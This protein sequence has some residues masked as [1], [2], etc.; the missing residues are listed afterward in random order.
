MV[1]VKVRQ[2][3]V[4]A[5]R[6]VVLH[7]DAERPHAGARVEH[8]RVPA[9][10]PHFH[11]RGVAAVAHGVGPRRGDRAAAAPHADAHQ[12]FP[13]SSI[14]QNTATAPCITPV[15]PSNGYAVAS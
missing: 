10:E 9:R 14:G 2:H 4:Q 11:A 3:D 15:A 6:H 1:E 5:G 13:S 7:R 8:D 12:A